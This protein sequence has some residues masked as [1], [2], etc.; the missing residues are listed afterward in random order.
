MPVILYIGVVFP[1]M[2]SLSLDRYHFLIIL[3]ETLT[4]LSLSNPVLQDEGGSI[5]LPKQYLQEHR[6]DL[7]I[8]F[9][10]IYCR[11]GFDSDRNVSVSLKNHKEIK[12]IAI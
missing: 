1:F 6:T 3:K 5:P 4:F 9:K 11:T 7:P 2:R 10:I 8:K 12:M